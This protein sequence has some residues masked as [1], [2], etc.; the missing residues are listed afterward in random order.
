MPAGA[1]EGDGGRSHH[2]SGA[3]KSESEEFIVGELEEGLRVPLL[4]ARDKSELDDD[5]AGSDDNGSDAEPCAF[6]DLFVLADMLDY[7]LMFLGSVCAV[8]AGIVMPV[9]SIIFGDIMDAFHG[10]HP[11]REVNKNVQ[12]FMYL[13]MVAFL[14]N[15]GLNTFF[16]VAAERQARRMRLQYLRSALRQEMGWFDTKKAGQLAACIKG[17]TLAVSQGIGIKLARLIQFF[18]MFVSGFMIGF[19]KGWELALVMLCVIPPLALAGGFMFGKLAG[20]AAQ[21]QRSNAAAAGVAEE[22]I[23]SIRTVVAFGGEKRE[24]KR[25]KSRVEEAMDTSIKSGI[26]FAKALAVMMFIIFCSYGLGMWYGASEVARGLRQGCVGHACVTGGDVLTVFWAILNGAMSIGQMGPNLQA[27]AEARGA[28]GHLLAVCRRKSSIDACSVRGVKPPPETVRGEVEFRDVHFINPSRPMEEVLDGFN[29][30]VEPGTT[31]AL[32]GASGAGKSMVVNLLE[33]FYDPDEGAVFLD[34]VNTK[35][36]NVQWLRQK[37]GL[38]SQG[39]VLFSESI[40]DNIACG[41]EGSTRHEVE[42]AARL[43]DAYDFV[44]EFPDGFDTK[45]GEKGVQLS[46]GQKQRIAIARALV[47]NPA[48]LLLDEAA[49]SLD[50]ESE[51]LVQATLDRLMSIKR[52]TTIVIAHRLSTIR[53]A[54]KICVVEDGR[55]VETGNHDELIRAERGKYLQLVK[56]QLGGA[57]NPDGTPIEE[58]RVLEDSSDEDDDDNEEDFSPPANYRGGGGGGGGGGGLGDASKHG[59]EPRL[60]SASAM[61]TAAAEP[62]DANMAQ[63]KAEITGGG[64]PGTL[65]QEQRDRLWALGKPEQKYLGVS[66]MATAFSGAMFPVFSLML[67]T[68]ITFFYLRDPDELERKAS[69]W[70]L[71]FVVLATVI[72]C[73][74]YVQVSS[75]TQIGARLTSRLQNMTFKGILRQEVA[76]FDREENSTE[77][78]TARLANEVTLVKNITGLNLNRL[79][80]NVVTVAMAFFVAFVFGSPLLSVVLALIMPLLIFAGYI[81]IKVVTTSAS[82]SQDSVTRAGKTATQAIE[83]VRTVAAFNLTNKVLGMYNKELRGV[84]LEGLRRGFTDGLALGLS[85]LISLGAYGFVFWWG[86]HRVM[87]GNED[88]DRMLKSLMAVMMSSQG[89]GQT[90]SFLGDSGAASA[91]AARIFA[92]VDRRPPI[93]SADEGGQRLS[94]VKGAVELRKVRFR[95]PARPDAVVFRNLRLTVEAGTTVAL[96]GASGN[97]RSTVMKLLLRFYDPEAGAVLL[98]GVDIR[99]LNVAWLRGQIGLVSQE[100][101]LFA[102]SIADNIAYG[103]EGATMLEIEEAARKA[104]AHDFVRSCSDGYD[105]ELGDKDKGVQLSIDQKQRIAIARAILKDPSV[106]LLDEATSALDAESEGLVQGALDQVVGMRQR[107]TIIVAHRLSTIRKAD[108]VCV[109]HG[110]NVEE[111]GSHDDLMSKPDSRYKILVDAAEGRGG[112]MAIQDFVQYPCPKSVVPVAPRFLEIFRWPLPWSASLPQLTMPPLPPGSHLPRGPQTELHRAVRDGSV[113]RTEALLATGYINVNQGD[114]KGVTP[115]II[116]AGVGN[117]RVV[118]VLLDRGAD[119]LVITDEG[120]T[121]LHLSSG[122]GHVAIVKMLLKAGADA[123]GKS[124]GL[125][126]PLHMAAEKGHWEVMRVLIEAGANPDTRRLDGRTPLF[127][128]AQNG[129]VD[130]V[131]EPLRANANPL[132]P[133]TNRSGYTYIA[134]DMAA[135]LGYVDVVRAL[136]QQHGIEGC[137]GASGGVDALKSAARCTHLST[138]AVLIEA[139]AVDTGAALVGA[140]R[141]GGEKSVKLLLQKRREQA[142]QYAGLSSYVNSTSGEVGASPVIGAVAGCRSWSHRIVRMLVDAGADVSLALRLSDAQGK[143]RFHDTPL[144]FTDQCLRE[145][146]SIGGQDATEEQLH[147]WQAIRRVL[148][149][150]EAIHA[151]SWSWVRDVPCTARATEHGGTSKAKKTTSTPLTLMMPLM[152]RRTVARRALLTTLFRHSGKL[153]QTSCGE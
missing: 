7:V 10:P 44:M 92:L 97:D 56:L 129:H 130:A 71:M 14:L 120:V 48:V 62:A 143:V 81:Q 123:E 74:Y 9:F 132:L 88:F 113:A 122:R 57:I 19:I 146:K 41:L 107:T 32:V 39:A 150:V 140:A 95:Y 6:L 126:A 137:G 136:L 79:Y 141:F 104:N 118:R 133:A 105:T 25:Y 58:S 147:V 152:R 145:K 109:V 94:V 8:G 53:D 102:T 89:V 51:R 144:A 38:V 119:V 60:S 36:L 99:T 4:S 106:L 86:G 46:G 98:D 91:A 96:V 15:T 148:M 47:K 134:L 43:A 55:V 64:Q 83:G 66:L 135:E 28:A 69:H 24:S 73:A 33:R 1:G 100:P 90:A 111:E 11:F 121:A 52:G 115:L 67:S 72:G 31:V 127:L 37:L 18:S 75:M 2:G 65:P 17:D 77:A 82:K 84:L 78:L 45:V 139:G 138:M 50:V 3:R 101:V 63:L 124:E 125:G 103:R 80:Q 151:V 59:S 35:D 40:A 114:E 87:E 68:I 76:W 93:D 128:A 142:G 13:A 20:L 153:Q 131:R 26:G 70:S 149:R 61:L 116:A 22:A 30:K 117:S 49:S 27:V 54:D 34:G 85:Q 12:Y 29:L 16:S 5:H 108:K 42:E 21:Y 23:S 112:S 110:G